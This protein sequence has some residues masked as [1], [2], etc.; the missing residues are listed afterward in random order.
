MID[1]AVEEELAARFPS[2]RGKELLVN[3]CS[4]CHSLKVILDQQ[5]SETEWE[6][7]LYGMLGE[8][9]REGEAII[10]YLV[11]HFGP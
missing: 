10:R 2:G 11:E 7:A 1:Q 4:S 3:Q 6:I 9:N 8:R 5:K